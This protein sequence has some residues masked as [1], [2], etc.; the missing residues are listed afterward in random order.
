M[1]IFILI[2]ALSMFSFSLESSELSNGQPYPIGHPDKEVKFMICH[3]DSI[4]GTWTKITVPL[5][6]VLSHLEHGDKYNK[7][8]VIC[9]NSCEPLD[10]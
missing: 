6:L 4:T 10:V 5:S 7:E 9:D 3:Y 8:G 2:L 1:K